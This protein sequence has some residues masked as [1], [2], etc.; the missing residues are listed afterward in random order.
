[1][2]V[3]EDERHAEHHGEFPTLHDA[4]VELRR[5]VSIPWDQAPNVAPCMSWETCG[6]EYVVIEYDDS[7]LTWK[8]LQRVRV[9]EISALGVRWSSGMEG[10]L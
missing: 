7:S 3:I 1:M 8:E 9:V 6:R 10:A 4:I 2:F 5:R